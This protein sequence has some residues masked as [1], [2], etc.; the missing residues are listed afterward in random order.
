MQLY[1]VDG[2]RLRELR[3]QAGLSQEELS[4]MIGQSETWAEEMERESR[5]HVLEILVQK[6]TRVFGV[7]ISD[8]STFPDPPVPAVLEEPVLDVE[9]LRALREESSL[10]P[11]ELEDLAEL[12]PGSIARAESVDPAT[13]QIQASVDTIWKLAM[14]LKVSPTILTRMRGDLHQIEPRRSG[15]P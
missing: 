15:D 12:E 8:L 11:A 10:S 9:K 4:L 1:L 5:V 7:E 6:L 13:E 3:E 2:A 14:A